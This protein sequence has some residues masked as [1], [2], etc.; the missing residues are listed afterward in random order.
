M[1]YTVIHSA[2]CDPFR[3]EAEAYAE[4]LARAG[5]PVRHRCHPGMVHSFQGLGAFL[6]QAM[7]ALREA[8][9]ELKAAL[10]R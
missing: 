8:G 10:S 4:L 2:E 3:D 5:V 7:G 9:E 6:P 1:P